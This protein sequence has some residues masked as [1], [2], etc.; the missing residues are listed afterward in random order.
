MTKARYEYSMRNTASEITPNVHRKNCLRTQSLIVE[1]LVLGR[2]VIINCVNT[3]KCNVSTVLS[4]S[5]T[6]I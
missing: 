1:E 5:N 4:L 3:D 6:R 2:G